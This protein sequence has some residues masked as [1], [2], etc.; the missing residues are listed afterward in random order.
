MIFDVRYK[1]EAIG[2]IKVQAKTMDEAITKVEDMSDD[3]LIE[4]SCEFLLEIVDEDGFPI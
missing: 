1:L 2:N 4:E 3:Q